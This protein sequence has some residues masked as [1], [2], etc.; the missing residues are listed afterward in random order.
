MHMRTS[1]CK[2]HTKC[3]YKNKIL[4]GMKRNNRT[5]SI[6]NDTVNKRAL[7]KQQQPCYHLHMYIHNMC[8]KEKGNFYEIYNKK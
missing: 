3:F 2:T 6:S 5:L 1:M 4:K 7:M 8:G